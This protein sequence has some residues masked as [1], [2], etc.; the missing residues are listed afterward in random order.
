MALDLDMKELTGE[1]T[2]D[3]L[4]KKKS[5]LVEL[6]AKVDQQIKDL[7]KLLGQ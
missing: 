5:K 2:E 3:E 7:E 1:I 4:T 6:E